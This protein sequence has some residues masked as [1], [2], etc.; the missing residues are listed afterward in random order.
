MF[1]NLYK[2]KNSELDIVSSNYKL[3]LD[4]GKKIIVL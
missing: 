2:T 4:G 1:E 3:F